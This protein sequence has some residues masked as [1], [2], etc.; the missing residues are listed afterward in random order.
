MKTNERFP[1]FWGVHSRFKN[2]TVCLEAYICEETGNLVLVGFDR[3]LEEYFGDDTEYYKVIVHCHAKGK[4]LDLLSSMHDLPEREKRDADEATLLLHLVK[5]HCGTCDG[6]TDLMHLCK[7]YVI[8]GEWS[9][10]WGYGG[11]RKIVF[12][13]M[14][15]EKT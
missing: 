7:E 13:K 12:G 4:L 10:D 1:I 11:K 6:A 8:S 5:A 2:A 3:G 9:D 14:E 15:D